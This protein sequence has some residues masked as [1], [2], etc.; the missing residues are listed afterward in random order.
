MQLAHVSSVSLMLNNI[1]EAT[2]SD[3]K[4]DEREAKK[5]GNRLALEMIKSIR[6]ARKDP[7]SKRGLRES[8]YRAIREISGATLLLFALREY[9][10]TILDALREHGLPPGPFVALLDGK[11]TSGDIEAARSQLAQ[12]RRALPP[13]PI[14]HPSRIA[15]YAPPVLPV[16][17]K[18]FESF[19]DVRW[20]KDFTA[21]WWGDRAFTFTGKQIAVVQQLIVAFVGGSTV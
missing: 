14:Q 5:R 21:A 1:E 6:S 19:R 13:R 12:L 20:R 16:E 8:M 9:K 15:N 11:R 17:G 4:A 18:E 3:I 10:A 2:E 7:A